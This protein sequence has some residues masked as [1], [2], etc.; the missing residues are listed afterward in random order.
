MPQWI[1]TKKEPQRF[2]SLQGRTALPLVYYGRPHQSLVIGVQ[3][4]NIGECQ[5]LRCEVCSR[6]SLPAQWV[7]SSELCVEV[8]NRDEARLIDMAARVLVECRAIALLNIEEA[9]RFA[10]ADRE[11]QEIIENIM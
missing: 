11:L 7:I 1:G 4:A 5:Y 2:P 8:R 3:G 6:I 10:G 9:R